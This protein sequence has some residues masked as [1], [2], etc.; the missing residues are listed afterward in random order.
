MLRSVLRHVAFCRGCDKWLDS[1]DED[2]VSQY[3]L[4]LCILVASMGAATNCSTWC[5]I[6]QWCNV[7]VDHANVEISHMFKLAYNPVCRILASHDWSTGENRL[8]AVQNLMPPPS[9]VLRIL[10]SWFVYMPWTTN[11]KNPHELDI[12]IT[13]NRHKSY[14]GRAQLVNYQ[15]DLL[16]G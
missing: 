13:S 11:N 4:V 1:W 3:E 8:G 16:H 15:C 14:K 7:F 2:W 5:N 12:Q 10:P 6:M 9:L